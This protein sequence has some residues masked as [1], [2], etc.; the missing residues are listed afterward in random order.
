MI[1]KEDKRQIK[2]IVFFDLNQKR[3]KQSDI[4]DLFYIN[5]LIKYI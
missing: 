3:Y 1:N 5:L 2:L 4:E